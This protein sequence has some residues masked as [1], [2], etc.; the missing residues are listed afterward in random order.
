[1]QH[2]SLGNHSTRPAAMPVK[3]GRRVR[4]IL[5]ADDSILQRM[6]T[7][8]MLEAEGY[9]VLEAA[10]GRE[11]VDLVHL[12]RPD[13]ILMDVAMPSMDGVTAARRIRGQADDVAEVP[14]VFLSALDAAGDRA[15]ALAAGGDDYLVK[16]F[17]ERELLRAVERLTTRR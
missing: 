7:R 14:I 6:M 16:P 5:L 17:S 3:A 4:T 1:M 13:L 2:H 9:Q 12:A 8:A 11:V 15:S 10:D